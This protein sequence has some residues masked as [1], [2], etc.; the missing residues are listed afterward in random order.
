MIIAD[1][2]LQIG[3]FCFPDLNQCYLHKNLTNGFL[4]SLT[5]KK[6]LAELLQQTYKFRS[7]IKALYENG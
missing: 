6:N 2:F 7:K 4:V 1:P 3:K 5:R